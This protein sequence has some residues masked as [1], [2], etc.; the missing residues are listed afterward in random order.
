MVQAGRTFRIFVSSTFSDLKEERNALQKYVFPRLRELCMQHGCRFQAI[1]LRWGVSEEAGLDQQTMKICLEEIAR[2]QKTS[3]KPNFIILLGDRYGWQPVPSEIPADEFEKILENVTLEDRAFLL[4]DDKQNDKNK[5]WYRK[6]ENAA[7]PVYCLQPRTD[8][9]AKY[10]NWEIAESRLRTIL[11]NAVAA[12]NLDEKARLK[13]FASATEQEIFHGTLDLPKYVPDA[14]KHVFG[15]FRSIDNLDDAKKEARR[16]PDRSSLP[17]SEKEKPLPADFIDTTENHDFDASS[18]QKLV[19]LKERLSKLLEDNI[20]NYTSHWNGESPTQDHIGTLPE[21]VIERI[22]QG[23]SIGDPNTLCVAVWNRLYTVIKTEI[24]NLVKI[25]PLEKEI[26]AHEEFREDRAK[27]FTGREEIL[28]KIS[29]NIMNSH[30]IV[31]HGK[32]GS[33]K[34]ALMAKAVEIARSKYKH[35]V[36]ISRF[37]GATPVSSDGRSLL[38]SL[39]QEIMQEYGGDKSTVPSDYS[40]LVQKFSEMLEVALPEKPLIIF[41]DALDQISVN[42]TQNLNWLPHDLP[43][44][45]RIVTSILPEQ[46]FSILKNRVPPEYLLEVKEMKDFEGEQL[47][48]LCLNNIGRTLQSAQRKEVI[49]KFKLSGLPLYLKIAFEEARRWKSYTTTPNLKSDIPGIIRDMFARLSLI[50]NH[51][52]MIVSRCLGYLVAARNGLTEDELID[53]LSKDEDVFKDFMEHTY[54][55]PPEKKLPVVVWSRLYFDLEPYM[56]ERSADGTSLM[57]FYHRQLRE[58]AENEY[59]KDKNKIDRH[60][61]LAKYF[62]EQTLKV[63]YDKAPNIRKISELVYQQTFGE[64]WDDLEETLTDLLFINAKCN[65]GMTYDL[66]EDYNRIGAGRARSGPPIRTTWVHNSKHGVLCP[67]CNNWSEINPEYLGHTIFCPACNCELKLNQFVIKADWFPSIPLQKKIISENRINAPLFRQINE[68]ADFIRNQSHILSRYPNIIFQQAHNCPNKSFPHINV[69]ELINSGYNI[70]QWLRW[71]GNKLQYKDACITTLSGHT[72]CVNSCAYSS[73]GKKIISCSSDRVK[74]W[75]AD[76]FLEIATI[77]GSKDYVFNAYNECDFSPD[78]RRIVI[79]ESKGMGEENGIK[80]FDAENFQEIATLEGHTGPIAACKYS[81]DGRKIVSGAYDKTL[82]IWDAESF[83]ELA[84]LQGHLDVVYSCSFS[85]DGR[86][87]ISGSWDKTIKI[88]DTES[89]DEIMEIS[90]DRG[91]GIESCAYSPDGNV[92]LASSLATE[93]ISLYDAVNGENLSSILSEETSILGKFSVSPDGKKIALCNNSGEIKICDVKNHKVLA[94]SPKYYLSG[95]SCAFSPD[96]RKIISSFFDGFGLKIIDSKSIPIIIN[97]EC[98]HGKINSCA[99]SADGLSIVSSS[100]DDGTIIVWDSKNGEKRASLEIERVIGFNKKTICMFSPD[101][102]KILFGSSN[103]T[104]KIWDR[105]SKKEILAI[106][107]LSNGNIGGL[108][109]CTFSPDGLRIAS[110]FGDGWIKI[111]DSES[112]EEVIAINENSRRIFACKYSPDGRNLVTTTMYGVLNIWDAGSGKKIRS[113]NSKFS[114]HTNCAYSPDGLQI[115]SSSS[116]DELIE[117]WNAEDGNLI[118]TIK[119]YG[120]D[121]SFCPDGRLIKARFDDV[122]NLYDAKKFIKL[123][124]LVFEGCSTVTFSPDGN[125]LCVGSGGIINLFSLEGFRI[126]PL[127]TTA[128]FLKVDNKYA[129]RCPS[130]GVWSE[131]SFLD[132]GKETECPN[133]KN[134]VILNKFTINADWKQVAKSWDSTKVLSD[135]QIGDRARVHYSKGG[136]DGITNLRPELLNNADPMILMPGDIKTNNES[137]QIKVENIPKLKKPWWQ[138]W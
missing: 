122:I 26:T 59:L 1:D 137:I 125:N 138:F 57:S 5:G 131:I 23:E 11:R 39:C 104:I 32:S 135:Q 133:C 129:F 77:T 121:C 61:V 120:T 85:P 14:R 16:Q 36:I 117:I 68:F 111:F 56:M 28:S 34:S 73:D 62:R 87:I 7:P 105:V 99:Y 78:S 71:W 37:I 107:G 33:G 136:L 54:H 20:Q 13:Y 29:G 4:W 109:D 108:D 92:I 81:P 123:C 66:L 101:C 118:G 27:F 19:D 24:D 96:G 35:A 98:H 6:D 64:L 60:R 88:W 97:K 8:D 3:P 58:V 93:F 134:T 126:G 43:E 106:T 100:A 38:E 31:V 110:V 112:G 127:I 102:T 41:L 128:W 55:A 67:Y 45:T 74:I 30:P 21:D 114:V 52:E 50:N 94:L 119:E 49:N 132:L 48:E 86:R 80:I 90:V 18:Y 22:K 95:E 17:K 124:T 113:L 12:I 75:D 63:D 70:G 47:L 84:T 130:C 51:G 89:G 79:G 42:N 83:V 72:T 65:A 115:I 2:C 116:N 76:S 91:N 9:Y 25:E 44:H 40:A 10:A 53:T 69:N 46:S 103:G 15:F 82:K